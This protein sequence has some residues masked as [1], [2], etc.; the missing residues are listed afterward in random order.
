MVLQNSPGAAGRSGLKEVVVGGANEVAQEFRE[1]RLD[2]DGSGPEI[3]VEPSTCREADDSGVCTSRASELLRSFGV[4]RYDIEWGGFLTNHLAHGLIALE[5]LGATRTV[6]EQFHASYIDR[7]AQRRPSSAA[8]P[9]LK[10]SSLR[11]MPL[12]RRQHFSSIERAFDRA[13]VGS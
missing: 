2:V 5:M 13:I 1:L 7:L 12:G 4:Q 10:Q 6:Q 9:R 11:S 8:S 3:C